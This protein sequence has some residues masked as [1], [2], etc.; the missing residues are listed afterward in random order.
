[1]S[2]ALSN[3]RGSTTLVRVVPFL[4]FVA[5]TAGQGQF[6]EASRYWCY[7]AKTIVGAALVWATWPW[8]KEMRFQWSWDAA[9]VGVL[10]FGLW[11]GLDGFYPNLNELLRAIARPLAKPLG[12]GSWCATTADAP[13]PWNPHAHLGPTA[14]WAFVVVRLLGSTLV[15]PPL[16]ETFYRSFLYRYIARPAFE[17]LPL[18][19]FAWL[20]FLMTAAIFGFSHYEWLPGVLCGMLYQGL[21]LRHNRLGDAMTA[22]AIT[23]FLLGT[24]IIW[25]GA[26]HFW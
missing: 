19:C 23:N 15:V 22:H 18:N 26:W 25:K 5:I 14:A 21:V 7:F 24:W 11:V 4:A 20:P 8:V 10:V 3:W 1:M 16:E 9:L 17:T 6:G 2:S 12:L 13:P